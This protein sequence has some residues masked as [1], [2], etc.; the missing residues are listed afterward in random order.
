MT[1][2]TMPMPAATPQATTRTAGSSERISSSAKPSAMK[3]S[4]EST[5]IVR[6]T[7]MLAT[8]DTA[9]TPCRWTRRAQTRSPPSWATG[10]RLLMLSR[11]QRIHSSTRVPGRLSRGSISRQERLLNS[12]GTTWN[13]A[14]ATRPQP[15]TSIAS[16]IAAAPRSAMR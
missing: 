8:A 9:G 4:C 16:R 3:T 11:I 13:S 15:I 14:I 2:K 7:T 1:A 12:I 10:S 6:S 5:L